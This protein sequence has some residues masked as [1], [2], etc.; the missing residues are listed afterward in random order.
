[1]F[2]ILGWGNK[3]TCNR[4]LFDSHFSNLNGG[5]A[6]NSLINQIHLL[7]AEVNNGP[8]KSLTLVTPEGFGGP[9]IVYVA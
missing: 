7:G 1:M 6:G 8:N 4:P 2:S 3:L 5:K 9:S